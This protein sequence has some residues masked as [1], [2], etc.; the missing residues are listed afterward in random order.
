[1]HMS[2]SLELQIQEI[3]GAPKARVLVLDG[4]LDGSAVELMLSQVT[5]LLDEGILF[6]LL[7]CEELR[8]VNSTGLGILLHFTRIFRDRGGAFRL[9]HVNMSVYEIMEIIG[10]NT[11]LEI[12]DSL[13]EAQSTLT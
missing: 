9:V 3:P 11:L 7:D 2:R 1:M 8:Y 5:G 6:L 4:E 13:E 10:A 12:H